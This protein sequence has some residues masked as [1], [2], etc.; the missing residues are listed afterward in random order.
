MRKRRRHEDK[1]RDRYITIKRQRNG[2][3]WANKVRKKEDIRTNKE[4]EGCREGATK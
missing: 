3:I 2:Q 1:E 4:I